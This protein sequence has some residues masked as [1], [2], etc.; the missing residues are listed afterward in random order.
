MQRPRQ[1]LRC[2]TPL[3]AD[4]W[5]AAAAPRALTFRPAPPA[6]TP[7]RQPAGAPL[8]LHWA[9]MWPP[10]WA[11]FWPSACGGVLLRASTRRRRLHR[12]RWVP[13]ALAPFCFLSGSS[14]ALQ[15]LLPGIPGSCRPGSG[16]AK[17]HSL[18]RPAGLGSHH[19]GGARRQRAAVCWRGCAHAP[20]RLAGGPLLPALPPALPV[21]DC[22]ALRL[23]WPQ[24]GGAPACPLFPPSPLQARS[25]VLRFGMRLFLGLSLLLLPTILPINLTGGQVSGG[26]RQTGVARAAQ[27][28]SRWPLID[29]DPVTAPHRT[30]PNHPQVDRLIAAQAAAAPASAFTYWLP[31]APA[32]PAPGQG[33]ADAAFDAE[34]TQ[35]RVVEVRCAGLRCA[36]LGC[37]GP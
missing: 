10:A 13:A 31:P 1:L 28:C 23:H 20:V 35:P 16:Q 37:D 32:P 30:P 5:P 33:G 15:Q 11:S 17:A 19:A 24:A 6:R 36:G 26:G 34:S 2:G 22:T 7:R 12:A 4:P 9:C 27:K 25:K 18:A 8:S 29:R 21:L 3:P 14:R